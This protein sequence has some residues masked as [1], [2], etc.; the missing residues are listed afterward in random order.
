MSRYG[1]SAISLEREKQQPNPLSV[2]HTLGDFKN[3]GT[4]PNLRQ[5][6]IPLDFPIPINNHTKD[7]LTPPS[8]RILSLFFSGFS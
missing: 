4:P 6:V 3:W 1:T 5:R 8:G 2:P 7:P